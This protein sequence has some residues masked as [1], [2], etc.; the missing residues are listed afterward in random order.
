[1]S[2][3]QAPAGA[4]PLDRLVRAYP[5]LLAYL[6]LLVLYAWQSTRHPTPWLFT[7]E[8]EWAARSQGVAHHGVPELRLHRTA[9]GSLYEYLI[10]PAW[11]AGATGSAYAAAKYINVVVMTAALFPAYALARLFVPRWAALASGVA[12]AAIPSLVYTGLLIPESLAYLWSTLTLWL[13]AR[14]L[15]WPSRRNALLAGLA[16]VLGPAMRSELSMLIATALFAAVVT[17]ATGARGRRLIGSWSRRERI[18]A[19]VL[20]VGLAVV[21]GAFANHHSYSWQIGMHFH[22]RAFTYGLWAL[23]A[24]TIGVGVLPAFATLAWL[25][26]NRFRAP[27][28]RAL[29]ALLVGSLVA[30]GLYTAVKASYLSTTFAI[31]VEERNLI[32]L[33]PVVFTVTARWA[34]SG[35]TRPVAAVLAGSAVGYLLATTPYHNN[36]HFYSDAPGLSVLQWMN[37]S[38]RVTTSDAENLLFGILVG[39]FVLA[40]LLEVIARRGVP[41]RLALPAGALLAVAVVGWNLWGEAAAA[42]ASN[43]FARDFRGVLPTPPDWIDRAT[44]RA[45]TMFIGES[46]AGSNA[47]WSLEFWNQSI[48]DVWSVDA[49]APGPGPVVTPNFRDTSGAVEPQLP[50]RWVVAAPGVD[51][52][53]H[54]QET[55]GGLRLYRVGRP[56]R[57]ADA[58]GGISTDAAW[59]STAAWYYRFAT[60]GP[61]AGIATVSLSR[62]AA[63]GG[64]P[65][66]HITIRLSSLRIDDEGQPVAGKLLAVRR[67]IVRSN[68]CDT[69]VVKIPARTP[70][71]LDVIARGTFQPSQYDLRQLSAQ[72]GFGFTPR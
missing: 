43:S 5:L 39:S 55:V 59:M 54:L 24:F 21:A 52:A 56:I 45:R 8:L 40:L 51:P 18:G 42:D 14:T 1:V 19:A 20:L 15:L 48:K 69:T 34:A 67:R 13:L 22:D 29:G 49:T 17:A 23:G 32:Y 41:R 26:G 68:P 61:R 36:E 65:P 4:S 30:F 2:D 50:L 71:R 37:R 7:D 31:R 47:F 27:A 70:F 64:F 9:F 12:A 6:V 38:W 57:I 28:D 11:W 72:V 53:G 60:D 3:R 63:C 58:E 33:A 35:R 16:A 10:A 46:L 66:S 25:L 62:A 44:G